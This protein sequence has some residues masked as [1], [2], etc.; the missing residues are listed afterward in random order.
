MRASQ[1]REH[2]LVLTLFAVPRAVS[3][4]ESMLIKYLLNKLVAGR[5]L[6]EAAS[7]RP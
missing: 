4:I 3:G 2:S 6:Y 5:D 7:Q 1:G